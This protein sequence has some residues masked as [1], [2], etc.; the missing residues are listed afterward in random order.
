VVRTQVN[1]VYCTRR[2]GSQRVGPRNSGERDLFGRSYGA[3]LRELRDGKE[4]FSL[5]PPSPPGFGSK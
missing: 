3:F 2:L 4:I 5:I 1:G